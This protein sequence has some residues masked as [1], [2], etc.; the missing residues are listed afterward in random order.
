MTM[1]VLASGD[2]SLPTGY[3]SPRLRGFFHRG[4]GCRLTGGTAILIALPQEDARAVIARNFATLAH[5]GGKRLGDF[6]RVIKRSRAEGLCVNEGVAMP[7]I[8]IFGIAVRD[9]DGHPF[10]SVSL[11]GTPKAFPISRL[12]EYRKWLDREARA[13]G[14]C[15]AGALGDA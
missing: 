6:R 12:A 5:L 15:A 4:W 9:A 10:A 13:L 7:G 14:E 11:A 1:Y 2:S 8:N 3:T